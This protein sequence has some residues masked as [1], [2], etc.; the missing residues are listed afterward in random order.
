MSL[1]DFYA[2]TRETGFARNFFTDAHNSP[3]VGLLAAPFFTTTGPIADLTRMGCQVRLVVRFSPV[4]KPEALKWAFENPSVKVRYFTDSKFHTKLYIIDEVALVGSANLTE[5]GLMTNREL[6]IVLRRSRDEV[7]DRLPGL[8]DD[9]WNEA[10]VLNAEVLREYTAAFKAIDK[11]Q[12]EGAFERYIHKFVKPAA[13]ASVVVGSDRRSRERTFIQNFR[14]K[15]DEVLIPAHKEIF[16]IALQN[17]FGRPEF[18]GAD[19]QIEFGRFLGW[20]RLTQGG[21]E[22]WRQTSLLRNP[23]DRA[24]RIVHYVSIWQSAD[25]SLKRDLLE[26]EQEIQNISSIRSKLGNPDNLDRLSFDELFQC[27]AGCHAFRERLRFVSRDIGEGLGGLERLRLDF[28]NKN[29]RNAVT[30]TVGYL[31]SGP[32]SAIERAYDCVYGNYKLNGFGEACVMELLGWGTGERP[33]FNNRSIRGIRMLG[34]DV[35]HLVVGE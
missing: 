14:R 18:K 23:E 31:L 34:F 24:E 28:Q 25:R 20:L 12:D 2:N 10:D 33:P 6:S 5:A 3:R 29:A 4:T 26:A 15:Y 16:D 21:G 32:G 19:P 30:R 9:L 17:G 35:E 22:A 13:P 11:P 27:L 1:P 7:F 8:F